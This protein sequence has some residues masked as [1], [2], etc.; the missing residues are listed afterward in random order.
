MT[1]GNFISTSLTLPS[2]PVVWKPTQDW[3]EPIRRALNFEDISVV[4]ELDKLPELPWVLPSAPNRKPSVS[5]HQRMKRAR[6]SDGLPSS[7]PTQ[8]ITTGMRPNNRRSHSAPPS[9]RSLMDQTTPAPTVPIIPTPAPG[10][11]PHPGPETA[12]SV[13]VAPPRSEEPST[14]PSQ[15]QMWWLRFQ[16]YFWRRK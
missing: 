2:R 6:S 1:S 13:A 16:K 14:G 15:R 5:S 9:L 12:I 3:R 10:N 7:A 8:F 11:I 4:I